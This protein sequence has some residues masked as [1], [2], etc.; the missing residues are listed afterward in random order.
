MGRNLMLFE[1]RKKNYKI[2]ILNVYP[3]LDSFKLGKEIRKLSIKLVFNLSLFIKLETQNR[4]CK[5]KFII[6]CKISKIKVENY[7]KTG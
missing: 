7:H 3:K 1:I 6:K 2:S 5:V 4:L